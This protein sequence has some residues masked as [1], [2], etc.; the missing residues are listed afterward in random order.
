MTNLVWLIGCF[1]FS[2]CCSLLSFMEK[3][4]RWEEIVDLSE[5]I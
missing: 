5:F 3:E 4:S 1:D 2:F